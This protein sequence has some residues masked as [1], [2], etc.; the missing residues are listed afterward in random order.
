VPEHLDYY[1][2][3]F[4]FRF[5]RRPPISRGTRFFRLV[6]NLVQVQ[7]APYDDLNEHVSPGPDRKL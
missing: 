7:P 6:Q 4:T 2:D 5:D 1:L 3:P